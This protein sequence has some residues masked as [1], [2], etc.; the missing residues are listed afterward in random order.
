MYL[1][2]PQ[3]CLLLPHARVKD[4][5]AVAV[6][7]TNGLAPMFNHNQT[8]LV[9]ELGQTLSTEHGQGCCGVMKQ[10]DMKGSS[11]VTK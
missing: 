4:A 1:S 5:G 3:L 10:S 8:I 7:I 2:E 11:S 6:T 9:L